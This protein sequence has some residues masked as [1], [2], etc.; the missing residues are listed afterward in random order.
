MEARRVKPLAA[1]FEALEDPRDERGRRYPLAACLLLVVSGL[2]C[3]CLNLHQIAHWGRRQHVKFLRSLGFKRGLA[4]GKSALYE[5]LAAVPAEQLETVL[6]AWAHSV[7]HELS[8]AGLTAPGGEQPAG[9]AAEVGTLHGVAIDGKTL[10]G[11]QKQLA[12][13]SH[14]VSAVSH[15]LGLTLAQVGVERKTNEIKAVPELLKL[16]LLE[17]RVFTMDALLTQRSIAE[18]ITEGGGDYVMAVKGNQPTLHQT[19]KQHFEDFSPS[20]GPGPVR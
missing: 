7:L 17:G 3:G 18:T 19:L 10:R 4:P 6:A 2:L 16:L 5:L 15:R 13:I 14:L 1:V 11:S 12:D 9:G 8:A 20:P